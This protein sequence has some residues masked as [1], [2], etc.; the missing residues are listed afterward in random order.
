MEF[1]SE[2]RLRPDYVRDSFSTG[3]GVKQLSFGSRTSLGMI[4]A[5]ALILKGRPRP[6]RRKAS[7]S[8]FPGPA[9]AKP[10]PEP[11]LGP[12]DPF[13]IISLLAWNC[14]KR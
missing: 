9:E 5:T 8:K 10:G 13:L 2:E 3:S 12:S 7:C 11:H 14:R 6:W 4:E 1:L